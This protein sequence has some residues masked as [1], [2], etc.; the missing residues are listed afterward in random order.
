MK[1][2]KF[3]ALALGCGAAIL[4][5]AVSFAPAWAQQGK[6]YSD[7]ARGEVF[8]PLGELSFADEV[9]SHTPGTGRIA[10]TAADPEHTLGAPD[11]SGNVNDGS[12]LSL[13]CDGELVLRFVDNAL[14]DL[15]GPDL[16][17]FEVGP[18][19]EG[20]SL[21]VSVDGEEW[22][23]VGAVAGG[24]AEVDIAA[25]AS[26][27]PDF[28]FLKLVDDGQDCGT[29]FAG[30]DIDAVAAIGSALRFTLDASVLF[31]V[32]SADLRDAARAT[33]DDLAADLEAAGISEFT[34]IG[35]TDA[36]GDAQYNSALSLRRA[37]SVRAYLAGVLPAAA[38]E[39]SG[40]GEAEPLATNETEEGRQANRR[41]EIIAR[42]GS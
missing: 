14:V 23:E 7:G 2:S 35:H 26:E 38:I 28:R 4:A 17:I 29:Q 12:F 33:L 19:V 22:I 32:D 39:V 9:V 24:R 6:S 20:M 13:G 41:V 10:A 3:R 8:L 1:H 31:A 16:Y 36:T 15:D 30:A 21:A 40:R 37:E 42:A 18:K 25:V 34:V 5:S 11:Y 27:G